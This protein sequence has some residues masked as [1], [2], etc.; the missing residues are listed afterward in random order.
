MS[1]EKKNMKKIYSILTVIC[2]TLFTVSCNNDM[3]DEAQNGDKGYL[4]LDVTTLISTN[5][6]ATAAPQGYN[7][8]TIAVKIISSTGVVV[9][10]TQDVANDQEFKGNIILSPD[11]YTITASSAGWDGS[12][13]GFGVPYYAG[14]TKATVQKNKLVQASLTLT[15]ANV[16]VTVNYDNNFRTYFSQAQCIVTSALNDVNMQR[17]TMSSNTVGSA[18]FPVAALNF[19][20][21]VTNKSGQSFS[22]SNDITDVKARDH[23][24]INY[25]IAEAGSIGGVTVKVD[26]STQ[27]YI[28]DIEVPRKSSTSLNA[29]SA[30]TFTS[31]AYLTGAVT[32]KTSEFNESYLK[33]QWKKSTDAD[34]RDVPASSLTKGENDSYS[35]KLTGLTSA[36][37]YVFRMNY[38]DGN[39]NVNSNEATFTTESILQ[40]EN[41]GFENWHKDGNIWYPNASGSNYWSTSNSGSAGTM[42]ESYNVTTGVTSGAY[43]GTSANLQSMY[44]IIKFAAASLF[45]GTFDGMI[46]TNGA[47]LGWGVPFVSRPSALKGYM[48]YNTSGINRG[49]KPS[50]AGAPDKGENDACQIFCALLTERLKVANASNGDGYELTTS[51][52]WDSDP[53]I[54]AYGQITQNTSDSDW[55]SFKIPLVYRSLT[56]KP[57]YVLV[58]CSSSKWG[59]Y[60]YGSDSSNLKLDDFSFEYG[61]PTLQ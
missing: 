28:F 37:E 18:Y 5:T 20:L 17:F 3:Q 13:S 59:D 47:K 27:S 36:T 19:F 58:V 29:G 35:Y 48:K 12:D 21:A 14:S 22:M 53:R 57:K 45:T 11:T 31:F 38:N 26:D 15:Q 30:N 41:S 51:F 32:A 43:N 61:E 6:R 55:K 42:G 10:E 39:T 52:N 8:K 33:L 7:P 9:K 25:K 1:N 44:V 34:W 49:N 60:F 16:K 56:V 4:K 23:F 50:G 40:L 2:L 54:I 24:I 46:G